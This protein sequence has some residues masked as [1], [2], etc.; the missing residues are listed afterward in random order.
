MGVSVTSTQNSSQNLPVILSTKSPI[1]SACNFLQLPLNCDI[2]LGDFVH[3]DDV[4]SFLNLITKEDEESQY[5]YSSKAYRDLFRHSLWM[6]PGVREAKA[7]SK[8]MKNHPVF[9]FFDIVNVAGDGDEEEKSDTALAK[10]RNAIKKAGDDGYTITLSCGKLTT[11]VTVK[12]WNAVFMLAGSFSTSAANYL[13]TIFRVQSP[14]NKD[15]KIKD[16]CYV[17]DFAPDRTLKMVAESVTLSTKAGKTSDSDR[18]ILGEFLN[19]CPVISIDGTMMREYQTNR[20]L[21]QLKRAYAERAVQNG[22]DDNN[23][24]NDELLKLDDVD[25]AE[26]NKLKGIIGSSK[27]Q[28]KTKEVPV[29]N[30]TNRCNHDNYCEMK[31][32]NA[33]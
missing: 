23:L 20:L 25:L 13:Q 4:R 12:E 15:G 29:M 17:F 32:I 2:I 8:M 9:S 5:P 33:R 21:Q 14:C 3:A 30:Y 28:Q 16:N 24:Y 31:E 6:I 26:F 7:L 22:F 11:G 27:A 10:V 18:K 19:Y 1:I